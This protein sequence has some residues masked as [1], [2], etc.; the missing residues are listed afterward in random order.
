MDAEKLLGISE[1]QKQRL[2]EENSR[3]KKTIIT[4]Q[5]KIEELMTGMKNG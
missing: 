3:L 2:K 5:E 1:I 4:L